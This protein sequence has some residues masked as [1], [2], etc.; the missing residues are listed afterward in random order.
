MVKNLYKK[1]Y[2]AKS[3]H[4]MAVT[5]LRLSPDQF[6]DFQKMAG[7]YLGGE[8]YHESL[9]QYPRNKVLP[10]SFQEIK[11]NNQSTLAGLLHIEDSAHKAPNIE[12]HKG[13]GLGDAINSVF[14]ALWN[15]IGLGP[16]FNAWHDP[17]DEE[18]HIE[19]HSP[20][21]SY[22]AKTV[23][24]SYESIDDRIDRI[25]GGVNAWYREPELDTKAF[26]TWVDKDNSVVHVGLKGTSS[27]KDILS[28]IHVMATNTSGQEGKIQQ[29][30]ENVI[31]HYGDGYTFDVSG[32][33]LGGTELINVFQHDNAKLNKYEVINVFNPGV[34]PTHNLGNA[35]EA[36]E[37]ARF[38]F[39]LNS[40]D[41]VSNT[42]IGL[43]NDET[44]VAWGEPS[45]NPSYNHG[46]GQWVGDV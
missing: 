36:V 15:T 4:D 32:H 11:D 42:F 38:H 1:E 25:G 7:H 9:P 19:R 26:S 14:G 3:V 33:S 44:H 18:H 28:D 46:I 16:E 41:I 27:A 29:Y 30:L 45:H 17:I 39:F 40:G 10:S 22:Y 37:D 8:K 2:K 31:D 13:G 23:Q 5:L 12:F 20:K 43:V 35:K 21:D 34:M 24:Q 6:A